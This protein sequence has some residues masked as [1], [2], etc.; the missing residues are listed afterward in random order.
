[1]SRRSSPFAYPIIAGLLDN[2]GGGGPRN[3]NTFR[4]A[5]GYHVAL[6]DQ[7]KHSASGQTPSEVQTMDFK[8]LAGNPGA[9]A[10]E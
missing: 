8:I 6:L 10:P 3:R 5:E 9:G 7:I 1:L 2:A 4:R